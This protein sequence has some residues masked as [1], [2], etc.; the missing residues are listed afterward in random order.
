METLLSDSAL[1]SPV[2]LCVL[3]LAGLAG[4]RGTHF[5]AGDWSDSIAS[6]LAT[7]VRLFFNASVIPFRLKFNRT[8]CTY[9]VIYM[10]NGRDSRELIFF[11]TSSIESEVGE[12]YDLL[13]TIFCNQ[14]MI[15]SEGSALTWSKSHRT[16]YA[17][18][19]NCNSVHTNR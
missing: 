13:S 18:S 2:A 9:T 7:Y 6:S 14:S 5:P 16:H 11:L 15:M 8:F 1:V 19:S 12:F 10:N 17:Y 4:Q 3:A